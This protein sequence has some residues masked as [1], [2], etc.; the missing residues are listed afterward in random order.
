MQKLRILWWKW[1]YGWR[2][3]FRSAMHEQ[4]NGLYWTWC[5]GECAMVGF[6]N[7]VQNEGGV[8]AALETDPV[9][10]ADCELECWTD[11]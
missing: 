6:E 5:I 8:G 9:E 10:E 4:W 3:Y 7:A 11:G 2:I 1:R